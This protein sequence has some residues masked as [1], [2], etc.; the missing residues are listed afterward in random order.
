MEGVDPSALALVHVTGAVSP[1]AV[2]CSAVAAKL[3]LQMSVPLDGLGADAVPGGL[4][5]WMDA[6]VPVPEVPTPHAATAV[7]SAAMVAVFIKH[8]SWRA[9]NV[10]CERFVAWGFIARM[11]GL[12]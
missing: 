4:S 10:P 1:L 7:A 11:M 5:T 9:N 8:R 3:L 6:P 2:H 12:S